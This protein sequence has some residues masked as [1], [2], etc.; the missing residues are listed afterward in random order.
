MGSGKGRVSANMLMDMEFLFR[1]IKCS[2]VDCV[3]VA[4]LCDHT[5]AIKSI[6]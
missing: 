5:N 6:L 2:R 4:Q 3:I 1:V